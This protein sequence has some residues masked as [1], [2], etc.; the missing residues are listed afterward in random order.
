MIGDYRYIFVITYARSGST[1]LQSLVNSAPGVQIRGENANAAYHMYRMQGALYDTRKRGRNAR[2]TQPDNPWFGAGQIKPKKV[3]SKLLG[4]FVS[5]VLAPDDG[6]TVTGFKEVRHTPLFMNEAQFQGYMDY[7]LENFPGARILCNSRDG[8]KVSQS[9]F[10]KT[11]NA[12]NIRRNVGIADGWF[13]ALCARS[14]H[15]LHMQHED[16]VADPGLLREMFAFLDLPYDADRVRA[17]LDKPLT[18]AKGQNADQNVD[19]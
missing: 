10:L 16:Y 7:L 2:T 6:I 5:D 9:G 11:R 3:A 1:L 12:T 14:E 18:H 17:V 4:A 15:C 13:K 19:Q 8:E